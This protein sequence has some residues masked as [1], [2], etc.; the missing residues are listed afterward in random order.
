MYTLRPAALGL[1]VYIFIW[2]IPHTHVAT[3]AMCPLVMFIWCILYSS[4]TCAVYG[5]Y[6]VKHQIAHL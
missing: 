2:Q 5:L 1:Q 4:L 6:M 3:V